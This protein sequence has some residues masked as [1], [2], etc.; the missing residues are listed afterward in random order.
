MSSTTHP[1]PQTTP[2]P[3]KASTFRK[4]SIA[5]TVVLSIAVLLIGFVAWHMSYAPN[6][7]DYS[8]TRMTDAGLYQLSFSPELDPIAINQ[9]HRW[10]LHLAHPD[11]QPI[12]GA[13]IGVDGDMP[14]HGHGLPTRPQV[15]A[16]LG[17]GDYLVE[18]L[19]FH[20]P[21]WWIVTFDIASEAG[22]DQVTFNLLLE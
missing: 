6:D 22:S 18:G 14:Q 20:M 7:L 10:T 11:G 13:T 4:W 16:D 9:M 8:T 17:N 21:G 12:T 3:R 15:T 1:I 2:M 19:K 5:V